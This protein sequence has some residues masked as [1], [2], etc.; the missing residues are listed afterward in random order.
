MANRPPL[1]SAESQRGQSMYLAAL[2]ERSRALAMHNKPGYRAARVTRAFTP[3]EA[4]ELKGMTEESLREIA[5]VGVRGVPLRVR[6]STELPPAGEALEAEF[7]P[8]DGFLYLRSQLSLGDRASGDY[9]H[10]EQQNGRLRYMSVQFVAALKNH[11]NP[12]YHK[13]RLTE[14]SFVDDP[15]EPHAEV[16]VAHSITDSHEPVRRF[17]F[18]APIMSNPAPTTP[19]P[20]DQPASAPTQTAPTAEKRA[21]K[22]ASISADEV[23]QLLQENQRLTAQ[24]EAHKRDLEELNAYRAQEQEALKP[25]M[26]FLNKFVDEDTGASETERVL[27]K[28]LFSSIVSERDTRPLVSWLARAL[29]TSAKNAAELAKLNEERQQEADT[30]AELSNSLRTA[31][32]SLMP[33]QQP[34]VVSHSADRAGKPTALAMS[35]ADRI[36]RSLDE[37]EGRIPAGKRTI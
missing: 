24:Q 8:S 35:I 37:E 9:V 23:K 17:S 28:S 27:A 32:Q 19:A 26:E 33:Q 20:A 29:E 14:V 13:A 11:P 5:A 15:Y 18:C 34:M 22:T 31:T 4:A 12:E 7:N 1:I 25:R 2:R 3:A 16:L 21:P 10:S 36:K 30:T 6:H